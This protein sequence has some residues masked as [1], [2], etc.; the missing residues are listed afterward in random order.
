MKVLET[1]TRPSKAVSASGFVKRIPTHMP[2]GKSGFVIGMSFH[3]KCGNQG[4][5]Y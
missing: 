5:G 2:C 4:F 3:T 1:I